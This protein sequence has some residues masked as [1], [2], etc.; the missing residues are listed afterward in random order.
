ML[1]DRRAFVLAAMASVLSGCASVAPA[2]PSAAI[3]VGQLSQGAIIAAIN[4][5]RRANGKPPLR[6]N[7]RLEVAA[8]SQ[9]RAMVA[10]DQLSHD[11]GST[12][13][14]RVTAAGYEG[15]VGENLAAGQ[16]TL[17]QAIDGWLKSSGHRETLLSTRFV[18]F[19]LAAGSGRPGSRYGAFWAMV[20]SG[21]FEAWR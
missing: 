18:E 17:Q 2:P 10:K 14:Q 19:G 9:V 12:L 3:G 20:A 13:R 1:F 7:P 21:P 6:Y 15:A 4:G 8:R 5:A 16:S 11:L